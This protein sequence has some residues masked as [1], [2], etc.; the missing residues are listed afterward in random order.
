MSENRLRGRDTM[1]AGKREIDP[2]A[3][4]VAGNGRASGSRELRDGVHQRLASASKTQRV[5]RSQRPYLLQVCSCGE[6]LAI[7]GDDYR[8]RIGF[9]AE[10]AERGGELRN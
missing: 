10:L 1:L 6:E 5:R 7:A 9:V 8:S 2:A 4:E 3:H